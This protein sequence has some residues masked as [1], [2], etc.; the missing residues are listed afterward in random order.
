MRVAMLGQYPLDEGRIVGGVEAVMVPLVRALQRFDD[1][2]LH[3]ITCLPVCNIHAE[4][5]RV[6]TQ[7]E[8]ARTTQDGVPLHVLPRR[9]L[10][11]ATF[12]V[13]DVQSIDR[14]L[15][16][17]A[18]DVVHAQGLGIYASAALHSPYPHVATAH[19]IFFREAGFA[20]DLAARWRG[21]MDSALERYC[22][23]R[24][25]NLIC[26]SPYVQEELLPVLVHRR[27][28]R[29]LR[30]GGFQGRVF[31]I[32]NPVDDSFF[33]V[34]TGQQDAA[35]L[36]YAGRVVPRK[37]LLNLLQALVEVRRVFPQVHLRV[38]GEVESQ[39]E[40][41][42]AC[43][44]YITQH[45]LES[46]VTFLGSLGVPDMAREYGRCTLLALPSKQE[47]APV[48]VAEAMAAGRPVVATRACGMP[49][50]VQDGQ[51]GLLVDGDDVAAWSKA[52]RSLLTDPLRAT[53]MG[54]CGRELARARFRS[55]VV[56]RAT[57]AVY[58][59]LAGGV[60]V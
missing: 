59:E 5:Q 25:A 46:A 10:G 21:Y 8:S 4:R 1:L 29:A 37:G 42:D 39:S 27:S 44:K 36:L 19:G 49:Y 58:Q 23:H 45:A 47:T 41:V 9:R 18:P 53:Q 31:P 40:Y 30:R 24:I 38:A 16:S 43:R 28:L 35:T 7:A 14:T 51:T 52:L 11:R 60:H 3:V 26:I 2:E 57:R 55:D 48:V 50:L 34:G 6:A 22:L 13:R 56:A 15:R 20:T 12:H 32:E 17:L 33:E 54:V